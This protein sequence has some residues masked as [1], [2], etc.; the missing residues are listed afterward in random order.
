MVGVSKRSEI[1]RVSKDCL[2]ARA[3]WAKRT[4]LPGIHRKKTVVGVVV[5]IWRSRENQIAVDVYRVVGFR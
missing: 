1:L 5:S 2:A 3:S 4:I